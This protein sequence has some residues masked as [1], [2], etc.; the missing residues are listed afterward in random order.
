MTERKTPL[1]PE[2]AS[3]QNTKEEK[4][5]RK[6]TRVIA[7]GLIAVGFAVVTGCTAPAWLWARRVVFVP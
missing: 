5:W 2:F 4:A 7:V 6:P 1:A 3:P